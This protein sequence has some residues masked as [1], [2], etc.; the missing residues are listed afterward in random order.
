MRLNNHIQK[1]MENT[2][3]Y[4]HTHLV[5]ITIALLLSV[6]SCSLLSTPESVYKEFASACESG[7]LASAKTLLTE[8][9]TNNL[10]ANEFGFDACTLYMPDTFERA[11]VIVGG[12]GEQRWYA[13]DIEP[14]VEITGNTAYLSWQAPV[15][16]YNNIIKI[17]MYKTDGKW[18]IESTLLFH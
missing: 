8:N 5:I 3:K 11:L 6:T 16:D 18:K 14:Q 12:G 7:D 2:M 1:Q 10:K 15:P 17:T 9:A 13:K 4:H